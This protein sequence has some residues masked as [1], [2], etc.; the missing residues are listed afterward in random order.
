M[1]QEL[2]K[3]STILLKKKKTEEKTAI[4]NIRVSLIRSKSEI[5]QTE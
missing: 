3:I 4:F 5:I 2:I 1:S